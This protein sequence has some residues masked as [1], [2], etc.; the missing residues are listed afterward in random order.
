MLLAGLITA[1]NAKGE[2]DTWWGVDQ[3]TQVAG[4]LELDWP[5]GV[6]EKYPRIRHML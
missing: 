5:E 2:T 3:L 1:V 6:I 4:F